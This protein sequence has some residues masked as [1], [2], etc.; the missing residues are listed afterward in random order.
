M[1]DNSFTVLNLHTASTTGGGEGLCHP[2]PGLGWLLSSQTPGK[3]ED[4][5]GE[6]D[7]AEGDH[8]HYRDGHAEGL[9]S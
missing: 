9:D 1:T 6:E 4:P 5:E 3:E 2:G 8:V 7:G